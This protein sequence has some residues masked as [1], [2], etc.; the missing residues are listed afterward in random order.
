[1]F[2]VLKR[3]IF[4][5]RPLEANRRKSCLK[6]HQNLSDTPSD[7]KQSYTQKLIIYQNVSCSVCSKETFHWDTHLSTQKLFLILMNIYIISHRNVRSVCSK[8][9]SRWDASFEQT[10][11]TSARKI[12]IQLQYSL[13]FHQR[14]SS[15]YS[16]ETSSWDASLKQ[17]E[18]NPDWRSTRTS[19]IHKVI[20]K[21]SLF[22]KHTMLCVLK[23]NVSSGHPPKHPKHV[24]DINEY[25]HYFPSKRLLC[26]LERNV[27]MRRPT[28]ALKT[29]FH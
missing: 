10:K 26:M 2:C 9:M 6:K 17:T 16:K 22:T 19:Q 12:S 20:L 13:T 14:V 18:E 27:S 11:H 28:P 24:L 5:R 1:M 15:V 21:N 23:R 7:I 25:I 29:H 4:M 8:E 3:N